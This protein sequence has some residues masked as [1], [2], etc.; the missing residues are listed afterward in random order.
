ML[1]VQG[2]SCDYM[3]FMRSGRVKARWR[4]YSGWRE[5]EREKIALAHPCRRLEAIF[6]EIRSSPIVDCGS[7]AGL[8]SG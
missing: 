4:T 2:I 3:E 7:Q 1:S 8:S 6:K 5:R